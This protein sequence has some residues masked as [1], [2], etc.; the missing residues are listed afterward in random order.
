MLMEDCRRKA[1]CFYGKHD[2]KSVLRVVF[3]DGTSAVV[4]YRL[5]KAFQQIGLGI[6]GWILLELNKLF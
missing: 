1:L 2:F 5:A 6:I 3:T 4:F